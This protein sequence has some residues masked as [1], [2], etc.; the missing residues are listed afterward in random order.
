MDRDEFTL[1]DILAE[2]RERREATGQ[3]PP[4]PPTEEAPPVGGPA[5]ESPS[6][7]S[8]D[9]RKAAA[10]IRPAPPA[11]PLAD[12]APSARPAPRPQ[13]VPPAPEEELEMEEE[14]EP[15]PKSKKK[16]KK[17]GWFSRR[18][19]MPDFDEGEDMYYG[20]QLKPIDEY[21]LDGD[22]PE[23]LAPGGNSF[24]ALF[25]DSTTAIDQEVEEN[26]QR[27]QKERRRRVAEAVQT[28]GVDEQE[29]AEEFGVVAPMPVTAFAAD[30]YARQH[31]IEVEGRG[32]AQEDLSDIQR[33]MLET[34]SDQTMEIKL[35]VLNSTVEL[36][37]I[38]ED[39][40]PTVSEEAVEKVLRMAPPEPETYVEEPAPTEYTEAE[41]AVRPFPAEKAM[42]SAGPAPAGYTEAEGLVQ[43]FPAEKAMPPAGPAPAGYTEAE[44][45]VQPFPAEKAM[46]SAGPAP[47]EYTEAEGSVRP[48]PAE[49]AMPPAG[50][51][52]AGYTEAEGLVQPFPVEKAMPSVGPAPINHTESLEPTMGEPSVYVE[53]AAPGNTPLKQ[54]MAAPTDSAPTEAASRQ[55]ATVV[56]EERPRPVENVPRPVAEIP[57]VESIYAYRPRSIP[58]HIIHAEVLQSAL[59]SES[60]LLAKE[61]PGEDRPRRRVKNKKLEVELPEEQLPPDSETGESIE[62]YTGPEDARSI[63]HELRGDMHELSLRLMTT[64]ACT[65]FLAVVNL[66]FGGRFAAGG[67]VG[68]MPLI[69]I[70]LTVLGAG[71]SIGICYRTVGNGLRALFSMSANSDSAAAVAA[72]AVAVQALGAVFFQED[73]ANGKLHLYAVVLCAVLF[74]NTAGKL[75]MLRR[76]HSNFRFVT[77]REQKYSVRTYDDYN[78]SLKM[79]KDVVAEKPLVAYQCRAGFLKRFLELSYDPDPAES[80]SQTLAPIGL[81]SSLVLCVA[82]LLVTKSVST[83]LSA[84]AAACCACVAVGNMLALNLPLSRLC[85][86]ARR[87][88]AM[89]VGYDAV[90]QLGD[91]NAVVCDAGELFPPGTV[92]LGGI[93]TYGNRVEA[94]EAIMAASALMKEVGGPLCSVFDQVISENEDALPEVEKFHYEP[95]GGIVGRVDG[96]KIYIG[97]RGLLINNRIEVPAREEETQY[98]SG[99]KSIV[100][101][102][103]DAMVSAML[104]LTYGAD[105]R[106][107][108]ELQRLEDSGISVLVRTTDP[109]VTP[110][111]V[112]RLFG[113]DTASVGIL[114]GQLGEGMRK[115]MEEEIPRADAVVATKGRMESMMN[116]VS[117]CVEQK[118]MTGL[119]V[120]VQTVMVVCGFLLVAFMACFGGMKQLSSLILFGFQLLGLLIL[121][122]LPKFRSR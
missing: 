16:K 42:P 92:V 81:L 20:I 41:G 66:I 119:L 37:R 1:E 88:G 104:V 58:T 105:R 6:V 5:Q 60:E 49:K 91:V 25:D 80:A 79:T 29:I 108:N 55:A 78:T 59:L 122:V 120:A 38:G 97:V 103:V 115:L 9:P 46:P 68:S 101:I 71:V 83:A 3:V 94:E 69:Y 106:K 77:S 10:P 26:F 82:S 89:V 72:V 51:A 50:P 31:G 21:R 121:I 2:E 61:A 75:T 99:N 15:A 13:P 73:L 8:P 32:R 27:L 19:K 113:V 76:I 57:Y 100:Y 102:A 112:S 117:A 34:S 118:R 70:I 52:P 62:D 111:L 107:K 12:G 40:E 24:K 23:D 90:E 45:L 48:F 33:A 67:E 64:G 30:P 43:P 39:T 96:K 54:T 18:K 14:D 35:N 109:N 17:W 110:A 93:K 28:A 22:V 47:A 85:K 63:S 98:A 56:M 36:Q 86:T 114:D 53:E 116:V 95:G 87:A 65:L 84:L 44:G 11:Q 7:E 4:L 74:V